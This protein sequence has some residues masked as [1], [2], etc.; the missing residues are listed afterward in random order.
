M[1]NEQSKTSLN[2]QSRQKLL[3]LNKEA[4]EGKSPH[5]RMKDI[6]K[7]NYFT[8]DHDRG[9]HK[10]TAL[11]T[12]RTQ[13]KPDLSPSKPSHDQSESEDE[14]EEDASDYDDEDD[15]SSEVSYGEETEEDKE[16]LEFENE[17]PLEDV[18]L[19]I[20]EK[21]KSP[22]LSTQASIQSPQMKASWSS[23]KIEEIEEESAA[24]DQVRVF[25]SSF[26]A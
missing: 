3:T 16:E 4:T 7:A 12:S 1:S 23:K 17:N 5:L 13:A 19:R 26:R 6:K 2:Q 9:S 15:D 21:Q 18:S 14:E 25:I 10:P 22:D 11:I 20:P 8:Q 24:S